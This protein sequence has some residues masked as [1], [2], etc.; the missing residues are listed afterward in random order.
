MKLTTFMALAILLS[1]GYAFAG[2]GAPTPSQLPGG[3]SSGRP[4]AVL[5]DSECEAAWQKAMGG[6]GAGLADTL[7]PDR[8]AKFLTDFPQADTNHDGVF[9]KAEFQA[10]CK[11]GLVQR[12]TEPSKP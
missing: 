4:S 9:S 7:S 2:G 1:G 12:S 11:S 5:N 6:P 3:T 10:A 8:G